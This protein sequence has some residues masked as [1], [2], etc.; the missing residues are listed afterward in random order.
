[1]ISK[2]IEISGEIYTVSAA[3]LREVLQLET[4]IKDSLQATPGVQNLGKSKP[5]TSKPRSTRKVTK[6]PQSKTE[7]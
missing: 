2:Q 6:K 7:Q 5:S 4:Y 3:T 1:M